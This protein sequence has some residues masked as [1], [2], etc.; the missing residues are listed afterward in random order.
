MPYD[1]AGETLLAIQPEMEDLGWEYMLVPKEGKGKALARSVDETIQRLEP[2]LI[3]KLVFNYR[4]KV[5]GIPG[6]VEAVRTGGW[7]LGIVSLV[8]CAMTI[9]S[10]I[11]LDTRARRKE[12]AIRKVNGAKSKDIYQMFGRAYIILI[13][14]SLFIA[15]PLCVIFNSF[16]ETFV[17]EL[18]P[19]STLSPVWPIALGCI[20]VIVL[21]LSIITYQIHK[22]MRIDPA[23]IIAKE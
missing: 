11:A 21:I 2:Q 8:I 23:R 12:V 7:I 5:N 3:N 9:F 17:T 22:V 19:K 16:V 6:F 14:I 20:V 18:D 13:I 15:I 1:I 10:T 4:E